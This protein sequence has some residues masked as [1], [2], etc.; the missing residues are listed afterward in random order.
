M[1]WGTGID[2]LSEEAIAKI[3]N[4]EKIDLNMPDRLIEKIKY[5][6]KY[7]VWAGVRGPL[8]LSLFQSLGI[9]ENL[10]QSGDP[11]FLINQ[12]SNLEIQEKEKVIGVNWG[13]TYNSLYGGNEMQ[14]EEQLVHTL[15]KLIEQNYKIYLYILWDEDIEASKRLYEKLNN[16]EMVILDTFLYDYHGLLPIVSKFKFTINFKMHASYLSLAA[17]TPFIALGYRFKVYDFIKS[18]QMEAFLIP[19]DTSGLCEKVLSLAD[20]IS[21][22]EHS[23]IMHMKTVQNNYVKKLMHPFEHHLFLEK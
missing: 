17:G 11:G 21:E 8:S 14:M 15:N 10:Q 20:F 19:T 4:K 18:V 16:P 23:I 6:F 12:E 2:S 5:V 1:I 3:E 22:N 7:S 9:S 13:T